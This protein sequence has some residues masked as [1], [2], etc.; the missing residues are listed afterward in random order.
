[1]VYIAVFGILYLSIAAMAPR[2]YEE[3]AKLARDAPALGRELAAK[4]GPRLEQ[5][6]QGI[7][8]PGGPSPQERPPQSPRGAARARGDQAAGRLIRGRNHQRRRHRQDGPKRWR[9]L[10]DAAGAGGVQC[11]EA[12]SEG[13]DSFVAY[14]KRNAPRAHQIRSGDRQQD[15][16]GHFLLFA[17]LMS[18]RI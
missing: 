14:V 8:A 9:I 5:W 11:P 6:V 13:I 2:L 12:F 4:Q 1:V 3:T 10:P 15:R 16:E 17:T 7:L 18:L